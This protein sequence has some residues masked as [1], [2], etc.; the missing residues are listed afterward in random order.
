MAKISVSTHPAGEN[1]LE[2]VKEIEKTNAH[3]LH[4]DVMDENF[5][6]SNTFDWEIVKKIHENTVMVLDTHLMVKNP[7]SDIKKYAKAGSS[8]ITVHYE[9]F[10]TRKGLINALK[11]I[12]KQNVMVGLS[13]KPKTNVE[14]IYSILSLVDLVLIMSVEPGESGQEFIDYSLAK[15]KKLNKFIKQKDHNVLI[16]V[17]GGISEDNYE[18]VIKAGADI[19]VM[20]SAVYNSQNRDQLIKKIDEA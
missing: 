8:I 2:Y 3:M 19:L 17:D 9:A 5:V 15:I 10:K 6:S 16:E 12:A 1:V 20:G 18:Q 11:L 13:I 7:R 4:L 14:N